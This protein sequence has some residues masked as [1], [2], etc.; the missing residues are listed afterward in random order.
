MKKLLSFLLIVLLGFLLVALFYRDSSPPEIVTL[1]EGE[2]GPS[3]SL[4]IQ[5]QD[6]GRGLSRVVV[7]VWQGGKQTQIRDTQYPSSW[8]PWQKGPTEEEVEVAPSAESGLSLKEGVFEVRVQAVQQPNFLIFQPS[9]ETAFNFTYDETPPRAEISSGPHYL[10][11]GG[12]ES[13]VYLLDE[14]NVRSGVQVGDRVF[15]GVRMAQS[16]NG[17]HL[18]LF[19]LAHDQPADVP[20]Q[21]WAEDAAGNRSLVK[22]PVRTFPKTFRQRTIEVDDRFISQVSTEILAN[23][24]QISEQANLLETY[25]AINRDLRRLNN[26]RIEEIT[27]RVTPEKLWREP[28]L[29]LSNSQVESA[30]ADHRTYFYQGR[31]IDRQTH[32]G[33]DLASLA[34]SPAEASNAGIIAYADYLGIYGNCVIIDHG[35]GLFSLYG[36]LS[37]IEVKEGQLIDRGQAIGKTG[38]TG[39]AGGDHLH[40][41]MLLQAVQVNPMEWWDPK[42]LKER[43]SERLSPTPSD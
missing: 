12:S 23:T 17:T 42:W 27:G 36:H 32:L 6:G 19:A 11:Q 38:Q 25:L 9:S 39:L 13:V 8:L 2:V 30:F 29:Q 21:L 5:I 22:L 15:E 37:S 43:F 16:A 3:N 14:E 41:S 1:N 28:F 40:F 26:T 34:R 20:I 4:R 35:L 24:D 18:C 10:R 31:E 33:F 7:S